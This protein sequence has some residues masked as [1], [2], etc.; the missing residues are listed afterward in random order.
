MSTQPNIL[1]A[2]RLLAAITILTVLASCQPE[3]LV[4]DPQSGQW[5]SPLPALPLPTATLPISPLPTPTVTSELTATSTP[6]PDGLIY[7]PVNRFSLT[8]L[9]GW[10]AIT[11]DAKAIEGVTTISNYDKR[12]VDDPPPDSVRIHIS[13]GV[14]DAGQSFE[15]WLSDRRVLETSPEYGAGGVTLTEPQPYTLGRYTGVT[16]RG[17]DSF[18]NDAFT[19]IYLLTSDGRIVGIGVRPVDALALSDVLSM[20]STLVILG[21]YDAMLP[22]AVLACPVP[23][24]FTY[25]GTEAYANTI[26]LQMPFIAGETWTVGELARFWE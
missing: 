12:L 20:L 23:T 25:P 17:T 10:Y 1:K 4:F 26:T 3:E 5:I 18:S 15:Q 2:S 11:P 22:Q 7:D 21:V 8:L 6:L 19:I 9:P 14:L 24:D 13:I 16:Y